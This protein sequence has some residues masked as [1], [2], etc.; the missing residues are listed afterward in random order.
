MAN[1]LPLAKRVQIL[2]LLCEGVSLR[3]ISRLQDVSINTVSKL[4]VD[5]GETCLDLHDQLVTHV[6]AKNVQCDE[7]WSF[8]YA[9]QKNVPTAKAAP[10]EAGDVWTWTAL[11]AD[12][13]LMISYMASGRTGSAAETFMQDVARRIT[14]RPQITSDGFTAYP[15][16]VR[17]AFGKNVDFAQLVKTY[18]PDFGAGP[19]RKYSPPV[20]TGAHKVVREGNPDQSKISTSHVERANLTMRM[21]MRRFTRLT[22]AHS[23]KYANHLY[24]LALFFMH[25][26]FVRQHKAHKLSPAMAA[27]LTDRLWSMEDIAERIDVRANVPKPRGP[28]KKRSEA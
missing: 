24:A 12:S 27:G 18:G 26:N 5:A 17:V 4:L 6:E 22:N 2:N 16:A 11:D 10:A 8:C 1:V 13:K 14:G 23:K 3:A 15:N 7:I 9:K 20:C 21:G 28:Y 19:E 25:Y